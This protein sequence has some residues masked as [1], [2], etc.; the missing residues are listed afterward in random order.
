MGSVELSEN[1]LNDLIHNERSLC[2][3]VSRN[4][5]PIRALVDSLL[6]SGE[7][8]RCGRSKRR[9]G[10]S[11]TVCFDQSKTVLPRGLI[12]VDVRDGIQI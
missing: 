3:L 4:I 10:M 12:F 7:D 9:G 11:C 8:A 5:E 2:F 1:N 6:E